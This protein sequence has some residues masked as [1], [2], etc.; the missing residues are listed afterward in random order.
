[1]DSPPSFRKWI[2][3][4]PKSLSVLLR[5]RPFLPHPCNHYAEFCCSLWFYHTVYMHTA[6]SIC[7]FLHFND[8]N[9]TVCILL[10]L[11]L[12]FFW[13]GVGTLILLSWSSARLLH[14]AIIHA[15][16]L[17]S[18]EYPH[19]T[20]LLLMLELCPPLVIGHTVVVIILVYS[21]WLTNARISH[22]T[23]P[24]PLL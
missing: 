24:L 2:K 14:L 22:N 15:V 16:N 9:D 18:Y 7:M 17:L 4:S 5:Y 11:A 3:W 10:L 12:G 23:P 20:I 6:V 21:S 19:L 1:M 13:G 8:V